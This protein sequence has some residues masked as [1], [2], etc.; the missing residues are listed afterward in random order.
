MIII[1]YEVNKNKWKIGIPKHSTLNPKEH[2]RSTLDP[3][4]T[5]KLT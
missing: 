5:L 3:K 4:C 1:F 2:K